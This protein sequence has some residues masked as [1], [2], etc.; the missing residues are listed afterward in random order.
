MV[1]CRSYTNCDD[2]G[3]NT[4]NGTQTT[5]LFEANKYSIL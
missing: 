2:S 1:L 3:Y 5:Y 4:G